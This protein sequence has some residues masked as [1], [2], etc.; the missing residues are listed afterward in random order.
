M[1][2]VTHDLTRAALVKRCAA[3]LPRVRATLDPQTTK[4]LTFL[5]DLVYPGAN[6]SDTVDGLHGTGVADPYRWLEDPGS[7]DTT[8]WI[9]AQNELT[10]SVLEAC[11]GR[12]DL[13]KRL[14]EMYTTRPRRRKKHP[15]Q[16]DYF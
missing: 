13:K 6:R 7:A 16:G 8:S 5:N 11:P 12:E 14:S 10:D 4:E 9:T 3:I 1:Q 2:K 15:Q